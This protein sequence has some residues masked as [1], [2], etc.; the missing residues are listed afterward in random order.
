MCDSRV[1]AIAVF[2]STFHFRLTASATTH[3][4]FCCT[5]LTLH[6]HT[7]SRTVG[8]HQLSIPKYILGTT[9]MCCIT[10]T[11]R[12]FRLVLPR[13]HRLASGSTALAAACSSVR[14]LRLLLA[15]AATAATTSTS[16]G[17]STGTG[18][19]AISLWVLEHP[20]IRL[21]LVAQPFFRCN[22]SRDAE[23]ESTHI[24][25]Q[26]DTDTGTRHRHRHRH[27]QPHTQQR[28]I[29]FFDDPRG[30]WD[31]VGGLP[32]P[33]GRDHRQQP[34]DD[35]QAKPEPVS[36][37]RDVRVWQFVIDDAGIGCKPTQTKQAVQHMEEHDA[38]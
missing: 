24:Q 28:T 35:D 32:H 3:G 36:Q 16:T 23:S 17:T 6:T 11:G 21:R 37:R 18:S 15:T 34:Q 9:S 8:A 4:G 19:M 26:P 30:R 22:A 20:H 31:E 10:S 27:R 12:P 1:C 14:A 13:W 29:A 2:V 33:H 7:Y 38:L 25:T 5:V